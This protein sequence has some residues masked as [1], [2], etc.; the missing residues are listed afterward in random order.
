MYYKKSSYVSHYDMDQHESKANLLKGFRDTVLST[1]FNPMRFVEEILLVLVVLNFCKVTNLNWW[2]LASVYV[3]YL[4]VDM[5]STMLQDY[6]EYRDRKKAREIREKEWAERAKNEVEEESAWDST[7]AYQDY[8][9][10]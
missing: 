1:I 5:L 10:D 4:I 8:S 6:L 7:D 3:V 2:L 9:D